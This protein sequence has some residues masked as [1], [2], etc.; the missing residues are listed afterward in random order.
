MV[1]ERP[2][3][4]ESVTQHQVV[5]NQRW[6]NFGDHDERVSELCGSMAVAVLACQSGRGMPFFT[7]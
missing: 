1:T 3:P 6:T 5:C 4:H 2:D 7:E